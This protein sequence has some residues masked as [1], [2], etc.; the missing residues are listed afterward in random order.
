VMSGNAVALAAGKVRAKALRIAA[1]ALE[2]D[3]DD[4]ELADAAVRVKGAP[5]REIDLGTVAVL[6]NPLRYAFDEQAKLATQFVVG[7]GVDA[8]PVA[9]DDEPGLEAT[10]FYSPVLSAC[11]YGATAAAR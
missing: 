5:E 2:A 9:D 4:L 6:A 1:E 7:R 8:P 10:D 3:P 11:A